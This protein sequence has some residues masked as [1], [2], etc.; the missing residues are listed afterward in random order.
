MHIVGYHHGE[1]ITI[2]GKAS[3]SVSAQTFRGRAEE[4]KAE[5]EKPVEWEENLGNVVSGK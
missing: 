5:K 1:C 3:S 4:E 2:D